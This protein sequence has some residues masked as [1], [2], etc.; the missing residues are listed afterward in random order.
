VYTSLH[1]LVFVSHLSPKGWDISG[2]IR[3]VGW[4]QDVTLRL[5]QNLLSQNYF[6]R[7]ILAL[8]PQFQLYLPSFT[9]LRSQMEVAAKPAIAR[10]K[11]VSPQVVESMHITPQN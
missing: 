11:M 3:V 8:I 7:R 1:G 4:P 2:D 6:L 5:A 10:M 9:S